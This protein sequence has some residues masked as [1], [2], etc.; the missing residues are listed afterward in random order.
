M[1]TMCIIYIYIYIY[2]FLFIYLFIYLCMY[3]YIYMYNIYRGV[4]RRRPVAVLSLVALPSCFFNENQQTYNCHRFPPR[5]WVS[6]ERLYYNYVITTI[7]LIVI[8]LLLLLLILIIINILL[9]ALPSCFLG[10]WGRWC[11]E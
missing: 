2:I 7:I 5:L 8:I 4:V 1:Y 11:N 10:A 6:G 3:I 9:R